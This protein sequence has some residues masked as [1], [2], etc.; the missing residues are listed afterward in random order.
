MSQKQNKPYFGIENRR[1]WI[2]VEATRCFRDYA[3]GV[4]AIHAVVA[5]ERAWETETPECIEAYRDFVRP[6]K[7]IL[8]SRCLLRM[9]GI[10]STL[11]N[12]LSSAL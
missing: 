12:S 5:S 10:D 4:K 6:I 9:P 1:D 8:Y 11:S 7:S 3:T 2:T